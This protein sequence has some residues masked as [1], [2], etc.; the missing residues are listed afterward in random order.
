MRA[1][2]SS[3]GQC[4]EYASLTRTV[5]VT[6]PEADFVE[7]KKAKKKKAGRNQ[8]SALIFSILQTHFPFG[9]F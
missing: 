7:I 1:A 4:S 2:R 8:N 6:F 9:G 3:G 5:S